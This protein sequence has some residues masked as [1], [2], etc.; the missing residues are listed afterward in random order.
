[1]NRIAYWDVT[2]AI[3]IFL[4]VWGHCIQ[5]L[6]A[7]KDYWLNDLV[8][9]I[10]YS[11]HMP[12]FMI[13]SGYFAFFSFAK[14]YKYTI[15]KKAKQLL[16]P[17]VS[18]YIVIAIAAMIFHKDFRGERILNLVNT[19]PYSMWFLKS[20]FMCYLVALTGNML[21][22]WRPWTLALFGILIL[23]FGEKLNYSATIS[24]LPFFLIGISLHSSFFLKIKG[25]FPTFISF[26][27]CLI[28]YVWM[29]FIWDSTDYNFYLNPFQH[30]GGG[31][32][33]WV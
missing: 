25:Y 21:Y 7:D 31:I 26:L 12:L 13:I 20:L 24:M 2:K 27:I 11:F 6:A 5:N 15:L 19:L 4:V 16:I 17:S 8:C 30:N 32:S 18:W 33:Q 28:L 9:Q 22:H 29:N 3:A 1:M 23:I 10:I 14:P